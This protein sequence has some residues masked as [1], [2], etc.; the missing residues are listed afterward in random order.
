ML[1][2]AGVVV[3]FNSDS[4]ELARRM[5]ME[6]AKSMRYGG[7]SP[8]EALKLVTLNPAKQ[9]RIDTRTGSLETGKDADFVIWNG[10]PLSAFSRCEETWIDGV[11]RYSRTEESELNAKVLKSRGEL[12]AKASAPDAR[13]GAAGDGPGGGPG[14]GGGAGRIRGGRGRPPSLLERMIDER[15]DAIWLRIARGLDPIATQP[16]DCGCSVIND[17]VPTADSN[18]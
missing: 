7:L 18:K 15:E 10:E 8:E 4:D 13:G 17:A 16:G 9:L 2:R 14:G 3:S 6:A 1:Q 5:N 11:R 12:L